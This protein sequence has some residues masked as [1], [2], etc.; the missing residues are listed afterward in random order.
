[1]TVPGGVATTQIGTSVDS[2]RSDRME[3]SIR[4]ERCVRL[5]VPPQ[6]HCL[7][8]ITVPYSCFRM[9]YHSNSCLPMLEEEIKVDSEG[10]NT[11]MEWQ[12][13]CCQKVSSSMV[14]S[15]K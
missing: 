8:F 9:Y 1:M 7:L 10:E 11:T 5:K 12:K 6:Y 14:V 13:I 4:N 15:L 3:C 2:L